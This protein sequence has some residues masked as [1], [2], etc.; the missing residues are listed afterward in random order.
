MYAPRVKERLNL[1]ERKQLL[2]ESF[3]T[4][5][6]MALIGGLDSMI[7]QQRHSPRSSATIGVVS[8]RSTPTPQWLISETGV[9]AGRYYHRMAPLDNHQ[10]VTF[11]HLFTILC[12][13]V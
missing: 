9:G 13:R 12:V 2:D 6:N 11:T 7:R 3:D 8:N 4:H 5:N 1:I 10:Q